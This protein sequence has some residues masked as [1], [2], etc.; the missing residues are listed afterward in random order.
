MAEQVA[1]GLVHP[2]LLLLTLSSCFS[3]ELQMS[4]NRLHEKMTRAEPSKLLGL[5][6]LMEMT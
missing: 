4:E 3:G 2:H 1:A 5:T 6:F